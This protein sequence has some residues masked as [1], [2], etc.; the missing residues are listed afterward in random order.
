LRSENPFS[1]P[2]Q[3]NETWGNTPDGHGFRSLLGL[4]VSGG[5]AEE[6]ARVRQVEKRAKSR[7]A[8]EA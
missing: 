4:I 6:A 7:S 5:R 1:D 2:A 3:L 8:D